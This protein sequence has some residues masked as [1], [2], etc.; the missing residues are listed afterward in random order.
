MIDLNEFQ[1]RVDQYFQ[2]GQRNEP[3]GRIIL[4]MMRALKAMD[5]YQRGLKD[6]A[7]EVRR[8]LEIWRR[9]GGDVLLRAEL[10]QLRE[11]L[12]ELFLLA[13][14]SDQIRN[15]CPQMRKAGNLLALGERGAVDQA[16]TNMLD[17]PD[18]GK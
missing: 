9:N 10:E 3:G 18:P 5:E 11:S 1:Q 17:G 12:R 14:M 8:D 2:C 6:A 4:D 15:D 16:N 13:Q 7:A